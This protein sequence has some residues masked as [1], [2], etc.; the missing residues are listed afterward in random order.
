[1]SVQN[2]PAEQPPEER[3]LPEVRTGRAGIVSLIFRATHSSFWLLCLDIYPAMVAAAIPWSTSAV[4]FLMAIWLV[5]LIPTIEA[6]IFLH[7]LRHPAFCLPLSFLGLAIIGT[8][9]ADSAWASRFHGISPAIKFLALPF[10]LY[11]FRRSRRGLWVL[12]TFLTSCGILLILSWAVFVMPK[13]AIGGSGETGVPIK[14]SIDQSQEFA[15]C[16]FILAY[17]IVS[18]IERRRFLPAGI[19]GVLLLSFFCNMMYVVS[20]RTSLLC[21]LILTM[22]LAVRH[23]NRCAAGWL[24]AGA[25]AMAALVWCTSPYLRYR[26]EQVAAEYNAYHETNAMTSTGRRIEF[27]NKSIG[28]IREAPLI[29]HGT[30]ENRALFEAAA[31]GKSGA[32]GDPI[33]NPHN[34]TLYVA[35]EWGAV[36]CLLLYAMWYFH[37]TLFLQR[38]LVSWIGLIV[39]TQ[40]FVSSLSNSHLFDFTEG[41]IYVLG[42]GVAG[43][44]AMNV[45]RGGRTEGAQSPAIREHPD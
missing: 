42:V 15:L 4:L 35:I 14:N 27:M 19:F 40:S 9:W 28:F 18:S 17:M 24:L 30:G 39:V 6:P 37:L 31:A 44:M 34:Q 23:L 11:H 32:A 36:G 3:T 1:M 38:G 25:A 16:I 43:G 10:L 45:A 12:V 33:S 26:V 13:W 5:I 22:L 8:L 7:F 41:W 29:G 21:M 2:F 20:S